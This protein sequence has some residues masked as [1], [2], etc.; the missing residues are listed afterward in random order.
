MK[1]LPLACVLAFAAGCGASLPPP[2]DRLATA[3]AGARSARELGA[4][5]EPKA[6]L[7]L[8]LAEEQISQAKGLMTEGDNRRAD[9][10]LQRAGADAELSV[11]LAKEHNA[12]SEASEAK[13]KLKNVTGGK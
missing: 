7:H 1:W 10:I 6:A 2:S 3:E 11:M 5:K 13:E 12:N 8:K 9:M 4:S